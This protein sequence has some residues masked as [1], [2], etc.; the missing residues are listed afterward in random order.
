MSRKLSLAEKLA[1]IYTSAGSQRNIASLVGVSHQKIGRILKA[2]DVAAG[3]Y[4]A[5]S[6]ALKDPALNVAIDA[7]FSI[8]VQMAKEQARA[9]KLPFSADIP[10]FYETLTHSDGKKGNRVAAKNT[11]W[12][13]N[14]QREQWIKSIQKTGK[15]Y[16]ATVRSV[17]NLKR[18][19]K[20]SE[21]RHKQAGSPRRPLKQALHKTELEIRAKLGEEKA[22]IFTA[23]T[24]LSTEFPISAILADMSEKLTRKHEPATGEQGTRLADQIVLQIDTRKVRN[25]QSSAPAAKKPAPKRGVARKAKPRAKRR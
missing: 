25:V 10:V 12:L 14:A 21:Q 3:G 18:Y 19:N 15:F 2:G 7:A 23:Y 8:H 17:V 9:D 22:P 24:P 20:Q 16:A 13:S 5:D 1:L 6:R 11:H 4:S